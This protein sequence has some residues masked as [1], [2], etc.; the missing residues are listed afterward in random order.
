MPCAESLCCGTPVVGFRAGAPE[1][2]AIPE[3]SEFV[4]Q[5]D[6]DQLERVVR[7][8]LDR[9]DLD[10]EQIAC[11]AEQKYS[12]QTMVNEFLEVYRSAL[13]N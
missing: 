12:V 3:F 5:G 6:L 11:I 8:W 4:E 7:V 13:W 1:Q 9:T 2:I 10:A